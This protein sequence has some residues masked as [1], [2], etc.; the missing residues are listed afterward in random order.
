MNETPSREQSSPV[1]RSR[2]GR[3][4]QL[5]ERLIAESHASRTQLAAIFNVGVER[6]DAFQDAREPMPLNYQ[7][8]LA[9]FV[10][11]NVPA[12]VRAGNQLRQQ[13]AAAIAYESHETQ[14]HDSPPLSSRGESA[15]VRAVEERL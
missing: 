8:R 6:I 14:T 15:A 3:A 4:A 1:A 10:I 7:A 9:L 2:R 5:L 12:L 11:A 13:V